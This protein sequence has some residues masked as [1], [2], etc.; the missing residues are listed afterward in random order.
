ML[1]LRAAW[2]LSHSGPEAWS[3]NW[4]IF[5]WS[6][7]KGGLA[8]RAVCFVELLAGG[9]E[10]TLKVYQM[11]SLPGW[12]RPGW[13]LSAGQIVSKLDS[14]SNVVTTKVKVCQRAWHSIESLSNVV[15]DWL[16]KVFNPVHQKPALP[17]RI[18]WQARLAPGKGLELMTY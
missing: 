9:V 16:T 5:W 14:L 1:V 6:C 2:Q 3:L 15:T 8:L 17:V 18:C 4:L 13:K 7:G 12:Q 10:I 11:L